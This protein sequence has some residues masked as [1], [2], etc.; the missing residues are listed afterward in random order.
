MESKLWWIFNGSLVWD[1]LLP[2]ENSFYNAQS[3]IKLIGNGIVLLFGGDYGQDTSNNSWYEG[4]WIFNYN[5]KSWK[6][7]NLDSFPYGRYGH[8]MAKIDS[9][10]LLMY[11]GVI[12][13]STQNHDDEKWLFV[14]DSGYTSIIENNKAENN[15]EIKQISN[16][17]LEILY[18][19]NNDSN[20][21]IMIYDIRGII[22][23]DSGY[24]FESRGKH[25][26]FINISNFESGIYFL[27][28][29]SGINNEQYKFILLK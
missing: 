19:Q 26:L 22:R 25:Q 13:G 20:N 23:F 18:S 12:K 2:K 7:L 8:K 4:T 1:S 17:D 15:V 11:G 5:E 29:K 28:I 16:N 27:N 3:D 14:L 24:N 21:K 10:K 6:E 9:N